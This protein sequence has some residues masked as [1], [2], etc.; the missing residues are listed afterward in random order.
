M[1]NVDL[2]PR[3]ERYGV[4]DSEV[5]IDNAVHSRLIISTKIIVPADLERIFITFRGFLK[6]CSSLK[7]LIY[8]EVLMI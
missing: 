8:L 6:K 7:R 4:A 2:L 1:H 3:L 5:C